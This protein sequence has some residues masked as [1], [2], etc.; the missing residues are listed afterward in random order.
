MGV[1][2]DI[3]A[4]KDRLK[5]KDRGEKAA[6]AIAAAAKAG[7]WTFAFGTDAGYATFSVTVDKRG[8]GKLAGTLPDG[9]KVNVGS[10]GVLGDEALAI[11]FAYAKK[12][13][14]GF[15][16]WV[17]DDGTA[18]LSD[19]TKL[20]MPNGSEY[21]TEVVAPSAT[22]RLPNG[23]HVFT[24]GGVS[25]AFTVEGTRWNVPRQNKRANPDPNPTGLK[26]MF[27]EKTGLARGTYTVVDGTAKTKYT[28]VGAV[29]G[30]RFYGS[31]Y[32]R[33]AAPIPAT[34]K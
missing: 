2:V 21:A 24:A 16:F 18:V 25:Q 30:G 15:V 29:V 19:L 5:S 1:D 17:K 11:P 23:E 4:G 27:T 28:V 14:L 12:G 34:A 6:A 26:L 20:K 13:S 7:T 10:Q 8:T 9:T 32:A 3:Q 31:A 22:H 33:N